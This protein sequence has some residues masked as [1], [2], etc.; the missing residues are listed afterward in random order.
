MFSSFVQDEIVLVPDR[1]FL[2]AGTKIERS[3]Y[4]GWDA[5]PSVRVAWTPTARQ[6]LWA[7][8]SHADRTPSE[9]DN[10]VVSNLGGFTGPNGP[11]ALKLLGN[12]DLRNEQTNSFEA[13]YR[14]SL[15]D[16]VSLDFTAYYASQYDQETTEPGTSFFEATPAPP[17]F[18]MPLAY[19][20]LLH[21]ESHRF[22]L[23]ANWKPASRWT[24]SPGYA[25]EQIHMY[26]APTSHDTSSVSAAEG[27]T[28]V[29]SVLL[30][31]HVALLHGWMWDASVYFVGHLKDPVIPSYTRLDTGLTWQWN[32]KSSL[33][34][35]G[36]NLLKD[37]H[38]EFVDLTGSAATTEIKRSVYAKF[39]WRF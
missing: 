14:T 31:S 2:T 12:V 7:A 19:S 9:L 11:V 16:K 37:R 39:T 38:E 25:F 30:R 3:Y 28:P 22:E 10:S 18:V 5:Q 17:T 23:A 24:I 13:G 29:N 15:A 4:N 26:L 35:V 6:T 32:E 34:F 36:Q 33:S 8:I 1:L 21:G 20:N 27:S